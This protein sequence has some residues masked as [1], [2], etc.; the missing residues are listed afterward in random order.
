ME[1]AEPI[2]RRDTTGGFALNEE[3]I[4]GRYRPLGPL[5]KGGGGSVEL[6]W[7]TRIQRRV[8]IKR[9]SLAG[10]ETQPLAGATTRMWGSSALAEARTAA[11][12][13][14]PSI[15]NVFDFETDGDD[16]LLIMEAIEGPSLRDIIAD[17]PAGTFDLDILASIT[18][19][20]ANALDFAHSNKV[21]HLDVKPDNVLVT[22]SGTAK[23][24]DFG[25]AQLLD[26]AGLA[27]AAGGT[28]GYMPPEQLEQEPLDES[29]DVFAL[30]VVVYEMLT[31]ANPYKSKSI[32]GS[33]KAIWAHKGEA[34]SEVRGDVDPGI[35]DVLARAMDGDWR[36]RQ[37]TIAAFFHDIE[38]YLG[39]AEA[40][41][42][43]LAHIVGGEPVGSGG[44]LALA[45]GRTR[46][47]WGGDA[48]EDEY[49]EDADARDD[50]AFGEDGRVSIGVA[51]RVGS[52]VRLVAGRVLAAVLCWWVGFLGMESLAFLGEPVA[53]C[54]S[55]VAALAALAKPPFG[56]LASVC[57]LAVGLIASPFG[58]GTGETLSAGSPVLGAVALVAFALW[59]AVIGRSQLAR[60]ESAADVNC[61]LA[62]APLGLVSLAPLA[63]LLAGLCLPPKRAVMSGVLS[64]A[65]ALVL[66][67]ATG[68]ESMLFF[69][70]TFATSGGAIRSLEMLRDPAMWI[71]Y[72]AWVL[73]ALVSSLLAT[74]GSRAARPSRP[75]AISGVV[76]ACVVLLVGQAAATSLAPTQEW[77]QSVLLAAAICCALVGGGVGLGER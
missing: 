46:T 54:V 72:A 52:G 66:G 65:L 21:L 60:R 36:R 8:A 20:V 76:I 55:S 49:D 15:V 2:I 26:A 29:S 19:S 50:G 63:P 56:A 47:G 16:A 59:F 77:L 3:L 27:H 23:V 70:P 51:G 75:L 25:I 61:A 37:A 48:E 35:D 67:M 74:R 14:H 5:G 68:S 24:T 40:G 11:M 53:A 42:A 33:L 28:I 4:L 13:S 39:D 71:A 7:D 58:T 34:P 73:A 31:G 30:A 69:E 12:L 43:K 41:I 6:C 18:T 1:L 32:E 45:R 57:M 44:S 9:M 17:T 22:P 62:V 64:G 10:A 38:P